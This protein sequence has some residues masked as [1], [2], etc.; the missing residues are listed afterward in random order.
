[1]RHSAGKYTLGKQP[2]QMEQ[3]EVQARDRIVVA[4]IAQIQKPQ[5][6]LVDEVEPEE[7]VI[8]DS[9]CDG[10]IEVRRIAQRR[11]RV[12]RRRDGQEQSNPGTNRKLRRS[13]A[14]AI[15]RWPPDRA[16]RADRNHGA[17]RPFRS[18][19]TAIAAH[20]LIAQAAGCASWWS[21]AR[22]S[23]HRPR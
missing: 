2:Q 17:I 19:P 16:A 9:L 14:I 8:A 12:P 22:A 21:S 5:H 15:G 7:S 20:S 10:E 18:N 4:R 11:R 13:A 3:P 6:L 23:D 1:M